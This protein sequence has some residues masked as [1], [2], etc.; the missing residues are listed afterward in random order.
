LEYDLII[1]GG[2]MAGLTAGAFAVDAGYSVLI[3]EK[4]NQVGGLINSFDKNGFTFDSGIRAIENSG[5]V[6]PMLSSLG[7]EI[8]FVKSR[9]SVGIEDKVITIISEENLKDYFELLVSFYPENSDDIKRI[10]NNIKTVMKYMKVLY[11][12]EN[13][14]FKDLK[15]DRNYLFK[16]LLP[17]IGKFFFTIGKINQMNSPVIKHLQMFT[18]NQSL[19]DIICQH[20]FKKTPAFF[21]M[22]YFSVYLDYSYPLGGTGIIPRRMEEFCTNRKAEIAKNTKIVALDPD[23]HSVTDEQGKVYFYKKLIWASD[24]KTMYQCIDT[25]KILDRKTKQKVIARK[26]EIKKKIGGDSVFTLY[27]AVDLAPSYFS[28]ISTGHFFYTPFKTGLGKKIYSDLNHL[29]SLQSKTPTEKNLEQIKI[30]ISK[31]ISNT[32]LEISIPVLKDK[33]LAPEG[34]TGLILSVL[35]DYNLCKILDEQGLYNEI[36]VHIEN[37]MIDTLSNSIYPRIRSAIMDRFSFSPLSIAKKTGS[38]EGAITGWAFTNKGMPAVNKMQSVSK[39]V[40][41]PM[42]DIFQAGQWT[43]SPSGL[44]IAILTG[45]LA[46]DRVISQLKKENNR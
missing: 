9:V 44:P 13:P 25:N 19:I 27:L 21:A 28:E 14:I 43:Y 24:Q 46:A 6:F 15:H 42:S 1:V 11:G 35:F 20:F 22:S 40:L 38:S 18:E 45:K 2:G 37:C 36:K 7:I 39:S 12:I 30:W 3:C 32:T 16:V 29:L 10:I 8:E 5:I 33:N 26:N 23:N 17:W 41:T 31:Y 4:E 34:K